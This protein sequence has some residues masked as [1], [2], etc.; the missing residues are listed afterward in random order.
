[1]DPLFSVAGQGT[2]SSDSFH[3]PDVSLVHDLT[4]RLMSTGQI[5]DHDCRVIL[6]SD[7]C[8]I[9]DHR[10]GHLVDTGPVVVINNIF[11]SLTDFIFLLLRP[12]V[13]SAPPVLLCPRH[14]LF[15]GIIVWVIFLDPGYL[16]FFIEIF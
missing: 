11:G 10:T 2:L 3:I 14:H 5:A 6:D 8:Y 1:M 9:Q 13:L 4:M 16:F 15:S 12:P 7:V